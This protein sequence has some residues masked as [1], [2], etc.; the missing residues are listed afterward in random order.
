VQNVK[1]KYN[2]KIGHTTAKPPYGKNTE[3]YLQRNNNRKHD[4]KQTTEIAGKPAQSPLQPKG[5]RC[6]QSLRR[7][8]SQRYAMRFII[9][10]AAAV[11]PYMAKCCSSN[12]AEFAESYLFKQTK[13][14]NVIQLTIDMQVT[15]DWQQE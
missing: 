5:A 14:L 12:V 3:N 11:C 15:R 13:T 6:S 1:I 4:R 10:F 7:C 9:Y 2:S 8:N